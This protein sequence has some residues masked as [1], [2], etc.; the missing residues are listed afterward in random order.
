MKE[1]SHESPR[2]VCVH[3]CGTPRTGRSTETESSLVFCYS[4]ENGGIRAKKLKYFYLGWWKCSKIDL[5][6]HSLW[7]YQNHQTV[8]FKWGDVWYVN[9][10]SVKISMVLFD[11]VITFMPSS[12]LL[13]ILCTWEPTRQN[14]L[15]PL[16]STSLVAQMVK[17]LPAVRETQVRSLGRED[18]LEKEMATHSSILAWKIPMDRGIWSGYSPWDLKESDT[19]VRLHFLSFPHISLLHSVFYS[20]NAFVFI[21]FGSWKPN[22]AHPPPILA[23][24]K[25]NGVWVF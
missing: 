19:T 18:P 3:L 14:A 13:Q 1:A 4:L 11:K 17:C 20:T 23:M 16:I 9:Y 25:C 21:L 24:A 8:H 6:F 2:T 22:Q 10:S 15:T 12:I 5:K 7:I